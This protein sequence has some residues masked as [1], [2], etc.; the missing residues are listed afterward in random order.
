MLNGSLIIYV[1][2]KAVGQVDLSQT[3]VYPEPDFTETTVL[4]PQTE[5]IT[6]WCLRNVS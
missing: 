1:S 3:Q 5:F 4:L 2:P 6:L